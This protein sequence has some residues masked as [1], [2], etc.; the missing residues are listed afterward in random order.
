M[1][2]PPRPL[3][4]HPDYTGPP[5]DARI[6]ELRAALVEVTIGAQVTAPRRR[7]LSRAR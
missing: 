5:T 4:Q 3:A 2:M 6:D 7:D 1:H